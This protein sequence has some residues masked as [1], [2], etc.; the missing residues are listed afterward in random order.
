M[1]A[2]GRPPFPG[3]NHL[4]LLA[5]AGV[6]TND[7]DRIEIRGVPLKQAICPFTRKLVSVEPVNS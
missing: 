6:G 7:T 3:E 4:Q 1:A 5:A 2:Y